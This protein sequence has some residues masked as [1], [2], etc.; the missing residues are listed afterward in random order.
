MPYRLVWETLLDIVS[1]HVIKGISPDNPPA[2]AE[3]CV[4]LNF[5]GDNSK[6]VVFNSLS[7]CLSL[8]TSTSNV[9]F[10]R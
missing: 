3:R 10:L 5:Q 1:R 8:K 6:R 4:S 9:P 7:K 2:T